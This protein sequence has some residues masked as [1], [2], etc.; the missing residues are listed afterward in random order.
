MEGRQ[1][2]IPEPLQVVYFADQQWKYQV[3]MGLLNQ[4]VPA[5]QRISQSRDAILPS[6]L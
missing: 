6:L 5:T 4:K 1:M 2:Y 3:L